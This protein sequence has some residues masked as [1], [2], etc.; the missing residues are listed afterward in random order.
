M[1]E[2]LADLSLNGGEEL[3]APWQFLGFCAVYPSD[4]LG[5]V[6]ADE[7]CTAD[8]FQSWDSSPRR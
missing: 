7:G 5:S 1:P 8:T 3:S 6:E 4:V 2:N